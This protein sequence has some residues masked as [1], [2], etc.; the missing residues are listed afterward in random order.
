MHAQFLLVV[1]IWVWLA[2]T[3]SHTKDKEAAQAS[4]IA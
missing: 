2:D 3:E 4:A 1:L